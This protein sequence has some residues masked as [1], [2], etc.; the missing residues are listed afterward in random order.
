M[1]KKLI[2]SL[3]FILFANTAM[4]DRIEILTTSTL[5]GPQ[6][7]VINAVIDV[8]KN[9]SLTMIPAQ[10]SS[11]GEAVN[12]FNNAK[13]PIAIVWSDNMYK[14]TA[15]TKQNCII[16]FKNAVAVAVTYAPYEVCVLPGT[17]L[18]ANASYKFGNNKFNPQEYQ[19]RL[20]NT[21][22]QG[23]KFTNVTYSG[24]GPTLQGLINKE[25]DVALIATGNASAAIKKGSIKCLYTTGSTKYG[26]KPLSELYGVKHPLSE[27]RLGM[28]VF[29]KNF[30]SSQLAE[31]EQSLAKGNIVN[32]L[33]NLDM[34]ESKIELKIADISAYVRTAKDKVKYK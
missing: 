18:R 31:L 9:N 7:T 34:T 1:L 29:V 30:S 32:K 21:N 13:G 19:L 3:M 20:I 22:K 6:G 12:I 15:T 11:C 5:K 27:Y 8:T 33:E 2:I 23:M 10:K 17:T 25:I 4:A 14:H 16:N 28:M 26:Q 24:S